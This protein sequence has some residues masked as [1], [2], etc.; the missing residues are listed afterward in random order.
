MLGNEIMIALN[1]VPL[2]IW[3]GKCISVAE[4]AESVEQ[5]DMSTL[6]MFGFDGADIIS[7]MENN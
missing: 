2:F 1:E 5:I 7:K 3:E 6:T 4:V